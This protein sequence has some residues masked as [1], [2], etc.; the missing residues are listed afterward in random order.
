MENIIIDS[1]RMGV[2]EPNLS[3]CLVL[4]IKFS[5]ST[6]TP[7]YFFY[8]SGHLQ[9]LLTGM[10][11]QTIAQRAY[12]FYSF[13]CL[14]FSR[15]RLLCPAL[16]PRFQALWSFWDV[17]R[18]M[19]KISE[20]C[21]T[22]HLQITNTRHRVSSPK[23][24]CMTQSWGQVDLRWDNMCNLPGLSFIWSLKHVQF[25]FEDLPQLWRKQS[26]NTGPCFYY[27]LWSKI[28]TLFPAV[29]MEASSI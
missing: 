14:A 24:V 8:L 6:A 29:L 11:H 18:V 23:Q 25:R 2:G 5:G 19:W 22:S 4:L 15:K 3:C 20:E 1:L 16:C 17:T 26:Y 10:S 9:V 7:V 13:N 28:L 21:K 27:S 12:K